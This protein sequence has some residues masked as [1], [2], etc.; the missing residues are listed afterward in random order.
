MSKK[1]LS[2]LAGSVFGDTVA[3]EESVEIWLDTGF[4]PLNKAI[5][6]HYDKGLPAGR[7]IE[8][9]GAESC[10]KTAIAT[11][12]MISAQKMGGLAMFMDHERSFMPR[13]GEQAG[14]NIDPT[15]GNFVHAA[16]DTF[17]K[18]LDMVIEYSQAVR[19]DK[20]IDDKAPI[21]VVFDSLAAMVPKSKF[22][23]TNEEMGMHDSLAL[24]KACSTT[25]PVLQ[26]WARKL[27]ICVLIL[28][29]TRTDPGIMFGDNKKTPGG[30]AKN[31]YY[32]VRIGLNRSMIKDKDKNITGQT[33][34]AKVTKN[35]VSKPFQECAWQFSFRDD[36]TGFLDTLQSSIDYLIENGKLV[37]SGAYVQYNGKKVFKSQLAAKIREAGKEQVIYDMIHKPS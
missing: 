28:N 16:P 26:H 14:L 31:F 22:A 5:S 13:L 2:S 35:K 33:I 8:I 29:Q 12:A 20:L 32:S 6:G 36:G 9:F 7:I 10:G 18:S 37:T 24:A 15:V 17:E 19:D 34:K 25:F 27:N 4:M 30:D 21:L 3:S 23:K 11:S 1:D